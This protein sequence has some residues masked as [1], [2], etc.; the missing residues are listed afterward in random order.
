MES[1]FSEP[2]NVDVPTEVSDP[3]TAGRRRR[4]RRSLHGG[5]AKSKRTKRAAHTATCTNIKGKNGVVRC[6]KKCKP[7]QKRSKR[8]HR[9]KS[10]AEKKH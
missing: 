3:L 5:G 9:C 8:T 4:S 7:S 6:M 2:I 10:R 1:L